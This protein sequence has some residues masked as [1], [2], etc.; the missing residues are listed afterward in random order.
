MVQLF[1]VDK[2]LSDDEKLQRIYAAVVGDGDAAPQAM[3]SA[4]ATR[5]L[6]LRDGLSDD[7]SVDSINDYICGRGGRGSCSGHVVSA[8]GNAI[9]YNI[10]PKV[11]L[12]RDRVVGPL[13]RLMKRLMMNWLIYEDNRAQVTSM[14]DELI[15]GLDE[16]HGII[17]VR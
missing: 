15:I 6:L 4:V 9:F 7:R 13:S 14:L 3:M 1:F 16:S 8:I 5:A 2:S 10:K 11:S 12:S 17:V